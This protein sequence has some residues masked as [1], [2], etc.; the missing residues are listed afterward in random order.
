[1]ACDR[2]PGEGVD[3]GGPLNKGLSPQVTGGGQTG[4]PPEIPLTSVRR[5]PA[6]DDKILIFNII[7]LNINSSY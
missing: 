4:F 5:I 2:A 7:L 3:G 6:I 1:M